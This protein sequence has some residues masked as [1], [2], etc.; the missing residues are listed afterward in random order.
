MQDT[1]DKWET[2]GAADHT[3]KCD[4]YPYCDNEK[5]SGRNVCFH[6]LERHKLYNIS[7]IYGSIFMVLSEF[8][9]MVLRFCMYDAIFL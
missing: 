4:I 8:M 6:M 5:D 3:E 9:K 2:D 1:W 7:R